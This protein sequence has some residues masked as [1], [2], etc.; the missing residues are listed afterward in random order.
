MESTAHH[1]APTLDCELTWEDSKD[2]ESYGTLIARKGHRGR[3][4]FT[5]IVLLSSEYLRLLETQVDTVITDN[6]Y[7]HIEFKYTPPVPTSTMVA[8]ALTGDRR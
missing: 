7:R 6:G 4:H 3:V 5:G 8:A 1:P 2:A